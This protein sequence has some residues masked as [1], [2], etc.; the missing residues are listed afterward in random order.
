MPC[1]RLVRGH[2]CEHCGADTEA[3]TGDLSPW[4]SIIDPEL[5]AVR[6]RH[7]AQLELER[8]RQTTEAQQ[9]AD[10]RVVANREADVAVRRIAE[11]VR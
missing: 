5:S 10:Q 6:K 9:R 8:Q 4:T 7:K 11:R 3:V 1:D 2:E